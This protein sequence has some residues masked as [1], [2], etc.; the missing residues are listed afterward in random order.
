MDPIIT[1]TTDFGL[2]DPFVGIMKGV[3]LSIAP[4]ARLVDICHEIEPQNIL[5]T[6]YVLQTACN[7]FPA[8]TVHLV[9]VDPGV[10]SARRPIT[11]KSGG[12]CFVAPDNGVLTPFFK[13]RAVA[14]ELTQSKFFLNPVSASFH[15][16]DV[17]APVA[18]WLAQGVALSRMGKKIHDPQAITLPQP[19][20][21]AGALHGEI[22]YADRFGNL[23]ANISWDA[24]RAHFKFAESVIVRIGDARIEGMFASYSQVKKGRFGVIINSWNRLEIFCREGNAAKKLGYSVGEPVSVS[25]EAGEP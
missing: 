6:A 25:T 12:H 16:R 8:K 14:Y 7:Y 17:F 4:K 11:V 3:I 15:G 13:Q 9:V 1:L 20:I 5:Q 23:S 10:G 22:I 24:L 19:K 21:K 18:A 2:K